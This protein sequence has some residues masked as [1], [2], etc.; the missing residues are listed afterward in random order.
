M[1]RGSTRADSERRVTKVAPT[2]EYAVTTFDS[3]GRKEVFGKEEASWN[4][5]RSE[6]LT[7]EQ[8]I[9]I[10]NKVKEEYQLTNQNL[11]KSLSYLQSAGNPELAQKFQK[12]VMAD[13]KELMGS[14]GT[15][16]PFP[17]VGV[18][19]PRLRD[20]VKS[21]FDARSTGHIATPEDL[22][23]DGKPIWANFE[24]SEYDPKAGGVY[25]QQSHFEDDEDGGGET[26]ERFHF[27][28]VRPN[29]NNAQDIVNARA[30]AA[31]LDYFVPR[32]AS[33]WGTSKLDDDARKA[34]GAYPYNK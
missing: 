9:G 25:L 22:A 14:F 10:V 32:A 5:A 21:L 7:P 1:A 13:R 18:S 11:D 6:K 28:P 34:V 27:I 15:N 30:I 29:P 3:K 19:D 24:V 23:K 8:R 4:K 17:D 2:K 12:R 20:A 26:K 33:A 16:T 31:Y